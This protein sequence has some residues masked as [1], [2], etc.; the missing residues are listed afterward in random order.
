M[1]S[2]QQTIL[3]QIGAGTVLGISG[4]RVT[5]LEDGIELPVSAGY[6]VRVILDRATDTYTV[7]RVNQRGLKTFYHGHKEGIYAEQVGEQA[8]RAAC[9]SSFSKTEW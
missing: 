9:F 8:Y 2:V 1:M 6:R 5:R 4:G 7:A 3:K